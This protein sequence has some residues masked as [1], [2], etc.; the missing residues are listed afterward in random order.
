MINKVPVGLNRGGGSVRA[1]GFLEGG[2]SLKLVDL[3]GDRVL[4]TT[5][6]SR[7]FPLETYEGKG[8]ARREPVD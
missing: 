8:F 7:P 5:Y 4:P 1:H 2:L 3:G 6:A